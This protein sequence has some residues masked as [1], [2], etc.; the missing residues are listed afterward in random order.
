[1]I[2]REM[3]RKN[4][5]VREGRGLG[6]GG[7]DTGSMEIARA[8]LTNL[9]LIQYDWSKDDLDWRIDFRYLNFI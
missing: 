1:M 7:R 5:T 6:L 8:T 9:F 4:I 3:V 2:V